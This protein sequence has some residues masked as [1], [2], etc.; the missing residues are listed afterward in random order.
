M[1]ATS[2]A[3]DALIEHARKTAILK[4]AASV[5]SWDRETN[6]PSKA[7][8]HRAEQMALLAG[9]AH[10]RQTAPEVDDW[11]AAC[12]A[13]PLEDEL[14]GVMT[15][16]TREL[17]RQYDKQVKVPKD[18]VEAISRATTLGN[19]AWASA[20]EQN[21]FATFLPH[22]AEIVN[23]TQQLAD[24][25]GYKTN[26]Y[27]ALLDEY[28]PG[29]RSEA[30]AAVFSVVRD[31]LVP[32]IDQIAASGNHPDRSI[33]TGTYDVGQ[34]QVFMKMLATAMGYDFDA[35]RLD[36]VVHPFCI[37]LGPCDHRITSR[38]DANYLSCGLY[39]V[40]HE[41]GHALYEQ[42]RPKQHWGTPAGASMSLGIHESQSR[43]WEN[44]I[45]RGRPFWQHFYP[46]LQ[47]VFRSQLGHVSLDD[48][49]F[50]VND[51]RRSFIRVEAD[52]GTYNLHIILRFELEQA[53]I[54]GELTAADVPDAWNGKFREIFGLEVP[55]DTQGCLQDVHWSFGSFGYFPTYTL[56]NLY[57]AQL[58]SCVQRELPKLEEDLANGRLKVLL[59]WLRDR[60]HRHGRCYYASELIESVTGEALSPSH[61]GAA[62]TERYTQLYDL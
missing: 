24:A 62:L 5:L 52:E 45:G 37:G 12:E 29:A 50:A 4:S 59:D 10:D 38:W 47:G 42:N 17:R 39:S 9:L 36:T 34:Q 8:A 44:A 27:D 30:I 56:G 35:G 31:Q 43:L 20:R 54:S 28:E 60:V 6:M 1:S 21:H 61:L 33:L 48:F 16:N 40:L 7:A 22:L 41:A 23:L 19:Q 46:Q 3:Y 13:E 18:L 25:V 49:V 26:R 53:L 11:L 15:T 32:L 2:E 51:V 55:D 14:H 58:Y 57:A